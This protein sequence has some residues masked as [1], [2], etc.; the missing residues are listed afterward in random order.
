MLT[1]TAECSNHQKADGG[2]GRREEMVI[3][4]VNDKIAQEVKQRLVA[5]GWVVQFNGDHMDT[6]CSKECAR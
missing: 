6:Y 4:T 3:S 1:I 5:R 2:Y